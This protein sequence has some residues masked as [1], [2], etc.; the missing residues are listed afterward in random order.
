MS[1]SSRA[2]STRGTM[3]HRMAI[4]SAACRLRTFVVWRLPRTNCHPIRSPYCVDTFQ[5]CDSR[6]RSGAAVSVPLLCAHRNAGCALEFAPTDQGTFYRAPDCFPDA[7]AKHRTINQAHR[8]NAPE[9][10]DPLARETAGERRK[11]QL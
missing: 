11:D 10:H 2:S 6:R 5:T 8:Q 9:P 3:M 4:R 7:V 1:F